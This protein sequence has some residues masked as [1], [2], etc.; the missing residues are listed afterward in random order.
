MKKRFILMVLAISLL[1]IGAFAKGETEVKP[2]GPVD[3]V[4]WTA[5]AANPFNDSMDSRF[6]ELYPNVNMVSVLKEGDPGNEYFAAVAKGNAP[7]VLLISITK[8]DQ[9]QNAGILQNIS[10]MGESDDI[11]NLDKSFVESL[12]RD[13]DL[14]GIP[15]RSFPML[16][17]YNKRLLAEAGYNGAPRNWDEML[18]YARTLTRKDQ[19]V[20]G[21]GMLSGQWTEWWFQYYVWQA[22]GD[23]TA[24]NGDDTITLTF[25][26]PAVIKAAKLYQTLVKEELIQSDVTVPFPQMVSLFAAGKVAMMPFASDWVNWALG[27]GMPKE[28]LGLAL[29]P[30]GPGG[31]QEA[32]IS[33]DVWIINPTISEEKKKA[34]LDYI[35]WMISKEFKTAFYT[36]M[37]SRDALNPEPMVRTDLKLSDLGDIPEE[38]ASV[39]SASLVA[40]RAGEFYGK[41]DFGSYVDS[42]VQQ[43]ISQPDADPAVIFKAAQEQAIAEG[44]VDS[45]NSNF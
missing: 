38:Y 6:K 21:Y 16:F 17:G 41:G 24:K 27:E 34:A 12:R 22:G 1:P 3:V 33:G 8:Y 37:A 43:I 2:A 25:D 13:G 28:D 39:L 36:D 4:V 5:N 32:A 45:F 9:Y 42:A 35:S 10:E 26:D 14:Y 15:N 11:A 44:A 40:N 18:E 29:F 23:L 31:S 30:A 19:G 7:D 20:A